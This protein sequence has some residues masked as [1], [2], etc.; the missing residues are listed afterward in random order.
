MTPRTYAT[1]SAFKAALEAR[2][3][4]TAPKSEDIS[5]YRQLRIYDR[6][7]ARIF[8]HFGDRVVLK[9]GIAMELR[10]ENARHTQ[11]LDLGLFGSPNDLLLELRRAGQIDL[12]D[13]MTFE[14]DLHPRHPTIEGDGIV[15]EGQR[16]RTQAKL[17]G[18]I[19]GDLFGV[20]VAVGDSMAC[21]PENLEGD[22]FF[23]FAGIS[24]TS[25][26]TLARE[27]HIAEKLHALTMPRPR[28]NSRLKDL[29][30]IALLGMTGPLSSSAVR[31]AVHATFTHRGTHL[32]PNELPVPPERWFQTYG[33]LAQENDLPWSTM[34]DLFQAASAFMNPLL[35]GDE[36][37]WDPGTWTWRSRP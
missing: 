35:Q 6:F 15:Y 34:D 27:V 9:G 25:I 16:F 5:R 4:A 23:S 2:I 10:L 11:D 8:D 24:R 26:R 30:D 17:A 22:D 13:Y 33:V 12:G 21:P 7:L 36:G 14:I 19:Y 29:P 20:D 28:E 32:P 37:E 1:P 18:K 3:K 31:A